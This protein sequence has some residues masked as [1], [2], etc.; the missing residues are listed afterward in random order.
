MRNVAALKKHNESRAW[1]LCM[2]SLAIRQ[3]NFRVV[4]TPQQKRR[5]SY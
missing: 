2:Q 1:N 3:G 5:V 4:I